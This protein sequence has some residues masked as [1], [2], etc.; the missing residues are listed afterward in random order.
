MHPTENPRESRSEAIIKI[1]DAL[2]R[3]V[4]G[5]ECCEGEKYIDEKGIDTLKIVIK[6][7]LS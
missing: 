6:N 2:T 5:T 4:R 1:I 3:V 7:F